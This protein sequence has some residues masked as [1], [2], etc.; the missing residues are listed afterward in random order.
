MSRS[1]YEKPPMDSRLDAPLLAHL[2]EPDTKV[3]V[4][5]LL[6]IVLLAYFAG[7]LF[8]AVLLAYFGA[9][10]Y[11]YVRTYLAKPAAHRLSTFEPAVIVLWPLVAF[12]YW[13]TDPQ[14]LYHPEPYCVV[15]GAPVVSDVARHATF[16]TYEEALDFARLVSCETGTSAVL[17]D[18]DAYGSRW[19]SDGPTGVMSVVSSNGTIESMCL[20]R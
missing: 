14:K 2:R 1:L 17:F 5:F 11:W 7:H 18:L 6:G 19:L 12:V 3:I 8:I 9:G 16:M 4:P 15:Y 20:V 10:S 13:R